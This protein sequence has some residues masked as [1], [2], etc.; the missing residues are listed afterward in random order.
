M[1]QTFDYIV[2]GAG[3]A[4]CVLA[5]RLTESG[6]HSVLLLEA[7]PRDRNPWIHIPIG[8][9]KLFDNSR[10]NWLYETEPEPELK[11]RRIVQP[12]GKVLGG[13]SSINGLLYIRGQH[14]DFDNWRQLGNVGWSFEDVL[15]YFMRAEDQENGGDAWHGTG[16][17]LAVSNPRDS[18]PLVEAFIAACESLGLPRND[19]FNG[20]TQE[21]V[22]YFQT[23]SRKGR[24]CSTAVG[25]LKPA[26]GRPN[27]EVATEAL[28]TQVVFDGK[29]AVGVLYR[30]GDKL[31]RAD[32]RC[33]V[34]LCGGAINSPQ[35][36]ELSGVGDG[37]R[38]ARLGIPVI[39]DNP[40]VGENLQDHLQAGIVMECTKPITVNDQYHNPL[41]RA[42][43]G[44]DYAVRRRGS[45]AIAAA[46][47][48]A[49]FKAAPESAT[50]DTQ[51]H[52][53]LFST[54]KRG[55]AL[56]DFSGFTASICLLR[57]ESRG[58]VHIASADPAEA[59]KIVANYLSTAYDRRVTL[60]GL[61]RLRAF[62]QAEPLA[63]FVA[64]EVTPGAEVE[65]DEALLDYIRAS[66]TT[67]YHPTC[68]CAMGPGDDAVVAPDLKVK[69]VERLRVVDGSIMP[70][71]VSGNT[72]AA[73]VMIGEKAADMIRADAMA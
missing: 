4:G 34:L 56:H 46:V 48:S 2:V 30:Q 1:S 43:M 23:T 72:N 54:D 20:A 40:Q 13:S 61:K 10:V 67:I 60:A 71:L 29:R 44:L 52:F 14:A 65:T 28:A 32:A 33:E 15:P 41:R 68:T 51:V 5:N 25:Y 11:G 49:F 69:G 62:L 21:G 7:G 39:H 16:G 12:R 3:S 50:P 58:S 8:Y 36:L 42:A 45:L 53:I 26:R 19:D 73:V 59:P 70:R 55:A 38:L 31:R 47:G 37:A 6:K 64:K 18:H 66:S 22:G 17:P 63:P 27:L 24:R 57:P 35:L 9:G